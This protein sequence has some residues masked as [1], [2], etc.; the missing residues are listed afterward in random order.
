MIKKLNKIILFSKGGMPTN[1]KFYEDIGKELKMTLQGN[2]NNLSNEMSKLGLDNTFLNNINFFNLNNDKFF[3]TALGNSIEL[4]MN[5]DLTGENLIE[6]FKKFFNVII[7]NLNRIYVEIVRVGYIYTYFD[8]DPAIDI[9]QKV[10][11]DFLKNAD[12]INIQFNKKV[13]KYKYNFNNNITI[14]NIYRR[15]RGFTII[16]DFNFAITKE[17]ILDKEIINKVFEDLLTEYYTDDF[18]NK[19]LGV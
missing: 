2:K 17:N 9:N 19:I 7:D 12:E 3:I 18:V 10:E 4:K 5:E 1:E 6:D 15:E 8:D 11:I 14:S 13:E 16:Q